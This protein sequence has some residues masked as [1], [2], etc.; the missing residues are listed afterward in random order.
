MTFDDFFKA[1]TGHK[2]GPFD[3]QRR[4]AGNGADARCHSQLINVPTGL[5]KTAAVVHAWLFNR[6]HFS[7]PKWP[8]RLVYCLPMRTLVEQ[9]RSEVGKWLEHL[10]ANADALRFSE[11]EL[12]WLT[13]YS[14]LILMGGEEAD[15]EEPWD[16]H[17]EREAILFGTQDMLAHDAGLRDIYEKIRPLL[18][19]PPEPPKRR[20]GFR[21]D[22]E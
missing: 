18:L 15:H 4:L 9:T 11:E 22:P 8:R 7:N 16:I 1:A 6:V 13:K 5:G 14:P 19:P 3:Y 12:E 17:P 21:T 2:Q 20:I 10:Q